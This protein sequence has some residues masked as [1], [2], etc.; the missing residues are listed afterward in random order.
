MSWKL[1]LEP[2]LRPLM[3]GHW[4]RS[5]GMTLGVQGLAV[6]AGGE[7]ALVRHTY[8]PGW[9]FPG[10]GVERGETL[11]QALDKEMQEEAGIA[12]AGAP[13]LFG[14][15]SNE[16]KFRGDHVALFIIRDWTSCAPDHR[17]EIAEVIWAAPDAL[18]A[19][20]STATRRRLAEV[21]DNAPVS[22]DW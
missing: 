18:P 6:N 21:F 3:Q 15:Y 2:V 19:E 17:D 11:R 20:T 1:R 12:L 13:Q 9:H 16:A 22:E 10:G 4:R 14:V 7:I 8:R 5:R